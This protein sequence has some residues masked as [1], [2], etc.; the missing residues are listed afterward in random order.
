MFLLII[1]VFVHMFCFAIISYFHC[2]AIISHFHCF[3]MSRYYEYY[4]FHRHLYQFFNLSFFSVFFSYLLLLL[5]L[6]LLWFCFFSFYFWLSNS[7][8][9]M[10]RLS[11]VDYFVCLLCLLSWICRAIIY[12]FIT[13]FP[14]LNGLQFSSVISISI[15]I[16]NFKLFFTTHFVMDLYFDR[17]Y[18]SYQWEECLRTTLAGFFS[19]RSS[20]AMALNLVK[21]RPHRVW[22]RSALCDVSIFIFM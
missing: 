15:S 8:S 9:N 1:I 10:K 17:F 20:L 3:V 6:L 5:L 16:L 11:L 14:F 13:F 4:Y 12:N 2:F 19:W 22:R 7:F 18:V 21:N